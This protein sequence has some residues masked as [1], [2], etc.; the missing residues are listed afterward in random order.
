M[1][2]G[3]DAGAQLLFDRGQLLGRVEGT[4]KAALDVLAVGLGVLVQFEAG[5][6]QV[7]LL[8]APASAAGVV[9]RGQHVGVDDLGGHELG[10]GRRPFAVEVEAQRRAGPGRPVKKERPGK[11]GPDGGLQS[12]GVQR[13][14][15]G[16]GGGQL[17]FIGGHD[18]RAL[19]QHAPPAG[20]LHGVDQLVFGHPLL[21]G[22]FVFLGKKV[23]RVGGAEGGQGG[24]HRHFPLKRGVFQRQ[25]GQIVQH[26]LAAVLRPGPKQAP[27]HLRPVPPADAAHDGVH[28]Q[29]RRAIPALSQEQRVEA[30]LP[31][32]VPDL[33]QGPAL[34]R[35]VMLGE[36]GR[37]PSK[38]S[39][40]ASRAGMR[41]AIT[42]RIS[43]CS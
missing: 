14:A 37:H 33:V 38:R 26:G 11:S 30:V 35:A 9:A 1:A 2:P 36:H 22:E 6:P 43:P 19:A 28:V 25:P 4:A 40:P 12:A 5:P 34:L 32:G 7:Q 18:R 10:H 39:A 41:A 29:V 27:G 20:C 16:K 31:R 8:P 13:A 21:P 42:S 24:P 23:P 17:F 15:A 3:M